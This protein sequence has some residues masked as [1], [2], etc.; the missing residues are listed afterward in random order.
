MN[1]SKKKKFRFG[2][3]QQIFYYKNNNI[4][5]QILA[6]EESDRQADFDTFDNFDNGHTE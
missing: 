5:K 6:A 1:K 2:H 4:F 3:I